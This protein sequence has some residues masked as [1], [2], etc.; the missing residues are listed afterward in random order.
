M[1]PRQPTTLRLVL[2]PDCMTSAERFALWQDALSS[3]GT[4]HVANPDTL[5]GELVSRSVGELRTMRV[6]TTTFRLERDRSM[7]RR[8]RRDHVFFN[9]VERG[10][11]EGRLAGRRIVAEK[12]AVTVSRLATAIDLVIQDATWLALVVPRVVFEKYMPWSPEFDARLFEPGTSQAVMLGGLLR[13]LCE[14]PDPLPIRE[15]ARYERSSLAFATACLGGSLPLPQPS[16]GIPDDPARPIRRFIAEHLAD[17]EL[18]VD[19]LCREFALSRSGLYRLMVE[20]A[21]LATIIRR[22]RL[23][24]VHR[25]IA[26]GSFANLPLAEIAKRWGLLD[27]RSFR[28]AFAR[29]FGCAPSTIRKRALAN[30]GASDAHLSTISAD[31]ERWFLGL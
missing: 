24:A 7:A 31:L 15:I 26:S 27:E 9:F 17:P 19:L 6:S 10:R 8:V 12:G 4:I 18:G 14:L 25:D 21:D 13:S 28:R 5:A 23:Q 2:D 30:E 22:M 29:E 16:K 11:V 20:S 3:A 1:K